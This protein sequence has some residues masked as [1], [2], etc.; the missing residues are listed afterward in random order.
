MY[1][2][3]IIALRKVEDQSSSKSSAAAK[4][5]KAKAK[6]V[7]VTG[8]KRIDQC[9]PQRLQEQTKKCKEQIDELIMLLRSY[10]FEYLEGRGTYGRCRHFPR[11]AG[12]RTQPSQETAGAFDGK[13]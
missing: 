1:L 3:F 10:K 4:D 5:G 6:V 2:L 9:I 11:E 8:S 12:S 7:Q 13:A